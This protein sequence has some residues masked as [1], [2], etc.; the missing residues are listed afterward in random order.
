M[1][2]ATDYDAHG[3]G[4][5]KDNRSRMRLKEIAN[6]VS[7]IDLLVLDAGKYS[8]NF[9]TNRAFWLA[10]EIKQVNYLTAVCDLLSV[11]KRGGK[12]CVKINGVWGGIFQV[13]HALT[14]HFKAVKA[15]KLGITHHG[16]PEIY[17]F[18]RRY[19]DTKRVPGMRTQYLLSA[20]IETTY[21]AYLDSKRLVMH[22]TE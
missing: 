10:R 3:K 6:S 8:E 15:I 21:E 19:D 1:I 9:L 4:S 12:M 2:V 17:L 14:Q 16:S 13:L 22:Y 20:L 11:L 18:A 5:I 7:G